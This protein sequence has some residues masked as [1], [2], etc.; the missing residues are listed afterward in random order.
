MVGGDGEGGGGDS[1]P[2]V[3]TMNIFLFLLSSFIVSQGYCASRQSI[4]DERAKPVLSVFLNVLIKK[5]F[6]FFTK[7]CWCSLPRGR[8]SLQLEKGYVQLKK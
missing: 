6:M 4:Y 5:E 1:E 3:R 2:R 8:S 7:G